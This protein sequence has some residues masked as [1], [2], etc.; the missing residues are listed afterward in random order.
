MVGE[1]E[2]R[3]SRGSRGGFGFWL[4][5]IVAVCMLAQVPLALCACI[6]S[7][8]SP[9]LQFPSS[10]RAGEQVEMTISFTLE[11]QFQI[12]DYVEVYL[13]GFTGALASPPGGGEFLLGWSSETSTL[14]IQ[15]IQAS[16]APANVEITANIFKSDAIS[17]PP[18]G[19]KAN[20]ADVQMRS[21]LTAHIHGSTAFRPFEIVE[22]VGVMLNTTLAFAPDHVGEP[23]SVEL[24]FTHSSDLEAPDT[25]SIFLSAFVKATGSNPE[26]GSASYVVCSGMYSAEFPPDCGGIGSLAATATDV[27]G[28]EGVRV[29]VSIADL[30]QAGQS[31]TITVPASFGITIPPDGTSLN[32][33]QHVIGTSAA[34]GPVNN[35]FSQTA[36]P[37]TSIESSQE[38]LSP[39]IKFE[40]PKLPTGECSSTDITTGGCT[41]WVD[42]S[43]HLTFGFAHSAAFLEGHYVRFTLP[44]FSRQKFRSDSWNSDI[45]NITDCSASNCDLASSIA[46]TGVSSTE[47]GNATWVEGEAQ[48]ELVFTAP[49]PAAR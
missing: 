33:Q 6:D 16:P 29:D 14:R 47:I 1:G 38:V 30:I 40:P 12:N 43:V 20:Q 15:Q 27:G 24:G 39:V 49:V 2:A 5:A 36:P 19:L 28:G 26:S 31:V 37:G 45:V 22:P 46:T 25:V 11:L 7:V 3:R 13:P 34:L 48:L 8:C 42:E 32:N 9:K 17:L 44:G 23:V 4:L 41:S 10:P 21:V 18:F 35:P